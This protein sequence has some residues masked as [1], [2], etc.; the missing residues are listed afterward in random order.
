MMKIYLAGPISG[1]GYE[2]VSNYFEST[3]DKLTQWNYNVFS[4]MRGK[5]QLRTEIEFKAHG[6]ENVPV[7][8]NHAIFDRDRW[9]VKSADVVYA[10]LTNSG[11]RISIGTMMELAWAFDSGKHV[12]VAMQDDNIHQHAFV[13]EA[14]H[15]IFNSHEDAMD[16]L[17]SLN[18]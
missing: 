9:M 1:L 11:D 12:I 6:Y 13:L 7:A 2:E 4:P 10:N 17:K 14:A 18:T 5:S 16:Y 15:I 3:Y 8:T